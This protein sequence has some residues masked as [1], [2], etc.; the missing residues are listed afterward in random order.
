M[1]KLE[2]G[3][4]PDSRNLHF[5]VPRFCVLVE[6]GFPGFCGPGIP[7]P[8]EFPDRWGTLNKYIFRWNFHFF[9]IETEVDFPQFF[10]ALKNTKK[11]VKLFALSRRKESKKGINCK[12]NADFRKLAGFLLAKPKKLAKIKAENSEVFRY[13]LILHTK[14]RFRARGVRGGK[15]G[16]F[17]PRGLFFR[18]PATCECHRLL[19]HHSYPF[20]P[21]NAIL[22]H[23]KDL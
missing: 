10:Q 1:H 12:D 8:P 9:K 23:R 21:R 19:P 5:A 11:K 13:S 15:I 14:W 18:P 7:A 2:F 16:D 3:G 20:L 6:S 4:I 22:T 17:W